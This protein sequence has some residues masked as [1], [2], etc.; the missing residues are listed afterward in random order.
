MSRILASITLTEQKPTNLETIAPADTKA[1]KVIRNGQ[2]LI[3]RDGKLFNT[4]GA[5]VE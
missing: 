2:V 3:L 1:V 4:L 5:R